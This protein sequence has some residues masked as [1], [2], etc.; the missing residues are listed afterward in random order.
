MAI[1][2]ILFVYIDEKVIFRGKFIAENWTLILHI[3]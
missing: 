1:Y 2:N 3:D